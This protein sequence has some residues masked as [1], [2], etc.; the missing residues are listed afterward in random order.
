[1]VYFE[2][3]L[4]QR[5]NYSQYFSKEGVEGMEGNEMPIKASADCHTVCLLST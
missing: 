3:S 4:H 5:G 1:M 2:E